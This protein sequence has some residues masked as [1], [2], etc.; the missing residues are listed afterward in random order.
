MNGSVN[1]RYGIPMA[2]WTQSVIVSTNGTRPN[3][4]NVVLSDT[5]EVVTDYFIRDYHNYYDP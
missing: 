5:F 4:D 3:I 1:N 2:K